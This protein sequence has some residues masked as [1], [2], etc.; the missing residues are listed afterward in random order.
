MGDDQDP[1][2]A[3]VFERVVVGMGRVPNLYRILAAA[4]PLLAAWV[5]FAWTLRAA[6][7]TERGLRELVIVRVAQLTKA[8]YEWAAHRRYALQ[9]GV[10]EEQIAALEEWRTGP[11][12]APERAALAM[13][14][15]LTNE[16]EL[17]DACLAELHRHF[18]AEDIVGLVLTAAFYSCVSRTVNGLRVPPEKPA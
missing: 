4:P 2:V 1:L 8:D 12:S 16:I 6:A 3:A 17:S 13:A 11:F 9:F 7:S 10:T 5:D 15:E 18:T 14:D